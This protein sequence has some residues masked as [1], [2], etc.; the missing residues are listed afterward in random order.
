MPVENI[1]NITVVGTGLIGGS[2]GLG[3]REAGFTGH[4]KGVARRQATLDTALARGCIDEGH[5]D[6]A[7]ACAGADLIVLASPVSAILET[8]PKL[9]VLGG[10]QPLI[11]DAGST[12]RTIVETAER[13]L[14]EPGRFVGAHPMAGAEKTG[15]AVARAN[16][17]ADMPVILTATDRTDPQAQQTVEQFWQMLGMRIV[18]MTASDAD[19]AAARISH[20]PHAVAVLL[21]DM[22]QRLGGLDV[23]STGFADVTRIASGD[24]DLWADIFTENSDSIVDVLD[25]LEQ[26]IAAFRKGVASGDRAALRE[27]LDR[28]KQK[29]DAW[30]AQHLP[31]RA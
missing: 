21:F 5:T 7:A 10:G 14:P 26:T 24:A 25:E 15:P 9:A 31:H 19:H 27:Q 6:L 3:L 12:K 28:V 11:T 30:L 22:A 2:I 4:I 17:F 29:R 18:H 16:L 13:V 23:S 1:A 20:V 8:L